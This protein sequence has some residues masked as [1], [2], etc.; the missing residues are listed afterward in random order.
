MLKIITFIQ[1]SIEELR[2]KV[3]WPTHKELEKMFI[4][5]LVGCLICTFLVGGINVSSQEIT[6]YI[7]NRILTE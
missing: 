5:F 7:Y 4:L 6:R 3:T 1:E 2:Y